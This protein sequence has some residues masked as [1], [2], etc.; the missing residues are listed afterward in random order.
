MNRQPV[1]TG[2]AEPVRRNLA[3][4]LTFFACSAIAALLAW[5]NI[6]PAGKTN[7]LLAGIIVL[8][9]GGAVV[10]SWL[11]NRPIYYGFSAVWVVA[12]LYDYVAY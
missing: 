6:Y 5:T 8:L 4:S 7:P 11:N 12:A 1:P 10:G 3:V 9:A 2:E